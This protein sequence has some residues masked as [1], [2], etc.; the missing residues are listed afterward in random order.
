MRNSPPCQIVR[1]V[2]CRQPT[3]KQ[4]G[5][6]LALTPKQLAEVEGT[7]Q[8]QGH[9]GWQVDPPLLF[10]LSLVFLLVFWA[11]AGAYRLPK[12]RRGPEFTTVQLDPP[13]CA[14][15]P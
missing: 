5:L 3:F 9:L 7:L 2:E 11:L 14:L 4:H 10:E 8:G 6:L 15:S 13:P 12:E 1:G